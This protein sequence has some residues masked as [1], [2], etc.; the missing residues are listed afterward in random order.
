MSKSILNIYYRE[1]LD[2]VDSYEEYL[3]IL[4]NMSDRKLEK[5]LLAPLLNW[6]KENN[7]F[8]AKLSEHDTR[9]TYLAL[10]N[11]ETEYKNIIDSLDIERV[12]KITKI[13]ITESNIEEIPSFFIYFPA[14]IELNIGNNSKIINLPK[15]IGDYINLE[16]IIF[17]SNIKFLPDSL[18]NL[19]NLKELNLPNLN[20]IPTWIEKFTKLEKLDL[21]FNE[22]EYLPF[23]L[24]YLKNLKELILGNNNL[25]E[26]P[27]CIGN[28]KE[29][30][31][32]DIMNNKLTKVPKSLKN[33]KKLKELYLGGNNL[34]ELPQ[35]IGNYY[36]LEDL[37]IHECELLE[38]PIWIKNFTNLKRLAIFGNNI[39]EFPEFW[40]GY[41]INVTNISI[42]NN[43]IE[44][45]PYWILELPKLTDYSKRQ[46]RAH[47]KCFA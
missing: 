11:I 32:L 18:K 26:L 23:N 3:F 44:V 5:Q 1:T 17:S 6:I 20:K 42:E 29:L 27:S 16:K 31:K 24:N 33:L 15:N 43:P 41:L 39:K 28:L 10:T 7:L 38:I 47:N 45:C 12:K 40:A 13:Y 4:N 34:K 30:E 21:S 35:W 9:P 14:L 25:E 46:L 22:L 8:T 2:K 37:S 36:K 19:K